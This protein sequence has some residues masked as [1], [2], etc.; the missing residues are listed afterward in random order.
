MTFAQNDLCSKW[1]LV[2]YVIKMN[3]QPFIEL[4]QS[5][6][7]LYSTTVNIIRTLKFADSRERSVGYVLIHHHYPIAVLFCLCLSILS[8]HQDGSKLEL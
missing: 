8:C 1:S 6:P 5:K 4:N 7:R 3:C 2:C